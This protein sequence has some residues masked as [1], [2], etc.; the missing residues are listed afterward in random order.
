MICARCAGSRGVRYP[1]RA[2]MRWP[3]TTAAT[4]AAAC[5]HI[6]TMLR[7]RRRRRSPCRRIRDSPRFT[8]PAR[9]RRT[10]PSI[11]DPTGAVLP[12]RSHVRLALNYCPCW[13]FR[14]RCHVT[15]RTNAG[16]GLRNGV[17]SCSNCNTAVV[18][19]GG[20]SRERLTFPGVLVKRA[21]RVAHAMCCLKPLVRNMLFTPLQHPSATVT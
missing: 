16:R 6:A 11:P 15:A 1:R 12:V 17:P 19:C 3:L 5:G 7:P 4:L 18:S 9:T 2:P 21:R 20:H 13:L 8:G 10:T 14:E